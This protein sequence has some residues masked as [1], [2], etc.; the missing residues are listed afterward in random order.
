MKLLAGVQ[1][2]KVFL[3][4]HRQ[5]G[6]DSVEE[7]RSRDLR[8]DLEDRE[9]HVFREKNK[10]KGAKLY[11]ESSSKKSRIE[12]LTASN[13]DVDDPVDEDDNEFDER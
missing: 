12:M 3:F 11:G 1:C 4:V 8:K 6:Q 13:L 2:L 9:K 10:E 7:V 5:V